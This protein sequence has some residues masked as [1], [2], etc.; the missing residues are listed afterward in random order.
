MVGLQLAGRELPY[1]AIATNVGPG[2]GEHPPGKGVLFAE[3]DGPQA[4]PLKPEGHAANAA[5]QVKEGHVG[6]LGIYA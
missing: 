4:G 6:N 2:A 3:R 5:E 1:V